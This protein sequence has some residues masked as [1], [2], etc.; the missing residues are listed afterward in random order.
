ML[1]TLSN[2]Q[3]SFFTPVQVQ[4]VFFLIDKRA[5]EGVSGPHFRFEPYDYGPFD[6]AVYKALEDLAGEGLVEIEGLPHD[7]G[8]KYRLTE[9][10]QIRGE[11]CLEMIQE[12][13]R[14]FIR[15]ASEFV[16]KL[17]FTALVSA[18]YKEFPEMRVNSIF[19]SRT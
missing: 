7:R 1:A 17:S 8:R 12:P 19:R 18:I 13:Y 6:R 5:A 2:A 11:Q 15:K 4:K 10:G 3:Q 9:A 14:S 16:R